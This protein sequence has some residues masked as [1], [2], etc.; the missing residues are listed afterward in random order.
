MLVKAGKTSQ[1]S[2]SSGY[3]SYNYGTS[4]ENIGVGTTTSYKPKGTDSTSQI[5]CVNCQ[6]MCYVGET[7]CSA[8]G[9]SVTDIEENYY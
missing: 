4:Y 8:C 2:T 1:I 6:A 5:S 3:T 7:F 9:K